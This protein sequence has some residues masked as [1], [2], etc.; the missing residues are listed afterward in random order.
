[1]NILTVIACNNQDCIR[2]EKLIDQILSLN[3]KKPKGHAL[4]VFTPSVPQENRDKIRITAEVAYKSVTVL[5]IG[6]DKSLT[7]KNHIISNVVYQAA[8]FIGRNYKTPWLWLEPDCVPLKAD[9]MEQLEKAYEEHP[10]R[11]LAGHVKHVT[12]VAMSRV[13]IYPNDAVRDFKEMKDGHAG[14]EFNF[15]TM[16]GKSKLFQTIQI[17]SADDYSKLRKDAVLA[18][19][20]KRGVLVDKIVSNSTL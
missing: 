18:H 12:N 13:A 8:E 1:M 5:P 16:S 15:V 20:D 7:D 4:I 6:L 14:F 2:A 10:S 11:Y 19:S 17:D 3:G 9:W